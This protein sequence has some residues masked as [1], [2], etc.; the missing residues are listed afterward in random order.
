MEKLCV[1]GILRLQV[2]EVILFLAR[3]DTACLK[4]P[5][6]NISWEDI[7]NPLLYRI[8]YSKC[9]RRNQCSLTVA[10]EDHMSRMLRS[11]SSTCV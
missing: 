5:E 7:R 11:V 2:M 6:C 8:E 1:H 3:S 10:A 9:Q 4:A